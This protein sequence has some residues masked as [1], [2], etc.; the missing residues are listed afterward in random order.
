MYQ[1]GHNLSG[2]VR[3]GQVRSGQVRINCALFWNAK[4]DKSGDIQQS[5]DIRNLVPSWQ[6]EGKLS[7]FCLGDFYF[8]INKR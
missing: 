3:S 5:L 8:V 2:Q 6:T 1:I 7:S 4:K